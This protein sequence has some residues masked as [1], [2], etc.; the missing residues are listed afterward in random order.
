MRRGYQFALL[1]YV[2]NQASGEFANVGVV[3]YEL[4]ARRLHYLLSERFGR[5]S[6]FFRDGFD[7]ILFR[8]AIE[9]ARARFDFV[10]EQMNQEGRL[11]LFS[12]TPRRLPEILPLLLPIDT[13]AL[14]WSG[15]MGGASENPYAETVALF[16][17]FVERHDEKKARQPRTD[18]DVWKVVRQQLQDSAFAGDPRIRFPAVIKG[19]EREWT[20]KAGWLNGVPQVLESL[21]FDLSYAENVIEKAEIWRGRL[22]ALADT[23]VFKATLVTAPPSIPSAAKGYSAAVD[24]LGNAKSVRAVVEVGT[25]RDAILAILSTDLKPAVKA[26][27]KPAAKA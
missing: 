1:R 21:A 5:L 8:E 19:G 27:D 9:M 3:V 18:K 24:I 11:D 4:G 23:E 7:G 6:N 12:T 17:E 16:R 15:V 13:T 26:D 14:Q 2:F 10:S 20:F 22:D 25:A